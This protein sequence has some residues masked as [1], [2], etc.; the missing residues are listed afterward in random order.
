M[1]YK[2]YALVVERLGGA[3]ESI[4]LV[5]RKDAPNEDVVEA[6]LTSLLAALPVEIDKGLDWKQPVVPL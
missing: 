1:R 4:A 5:V 6:T 2:A 3:G